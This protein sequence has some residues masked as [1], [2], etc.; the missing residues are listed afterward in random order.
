M[1]VKPVMVRP[2]LLKP[3]WLNGLSERLIVSHYGE[4]LRWE[5]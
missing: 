1:D 3:Q 5:R 4:Q 2:F